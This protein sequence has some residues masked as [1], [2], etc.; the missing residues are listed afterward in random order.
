MSPGEDQKAAVKASDTS[1]TSVAKSGLGSFL[2]L[3]LVNLMWAFQYSG[4][5]IAT[6]KL[7]P[8]TVTLLPLALST[9]MF[10]PMVLVG[11]RRR[12]Q[13][14]AARRGSTGSVVFGF[15][16]AGTMG[17]VAAQLGLVWGV[18]RSLA[19]NGSVLSLTIPVLMAIMAAIMLGERM[20]LLRWISF[21]LAVAGVLTVSDID[22]R[23]VDFFHG[24]YFAGNLL[25][26]VSC[27]G[28]AF[29][30]TYTKKLLEVFNPVEVFVYSF[31]VADTVLLVLMLIL[32]PFSWAKLATLGLPVWL[33]LATVAVFSLSV[34]M[35][36]YFWVI[37]HIEVTQASLSIYLLPVFGVW[38]S[39]IAVHE[40]ITT[41]L[42]VGGIL[43]FLS[44]FLVTTYE[45]WR[46]GHGSAKS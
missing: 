37:Q 4:A 12:L 24:R 32:E 7:G 16:L 41:Q 14:R 35:M 36:L 17:V 20:T 18:E 1:A 31:L 21:I 19:S 44:T 23:S 9:I 22:W 45:E 25:L 39:T 38:I 27:L 11:R 26:F 30:N 43:V 6:Q 46:K 29:Y 42:I 8:V 3:V 15:V 2:V 28:S 33:S 13:E 40:R 5:K 34:S 10:A